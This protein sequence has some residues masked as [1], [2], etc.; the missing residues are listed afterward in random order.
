MSNEITKREQANPLALNPEIF[1]RALRVPPP[2]LP[3]DAGIWDGFVDGFR[4]RR[5]AKLS[6][7]DLEIARNTRQAF[8][9]N[10]AVVTKIM[11]MQ[12]DMMT[13]LAENH[14]NRNMWDLQE[15]QA[16]AIIERTKAETKIMEENSKFN[17]ARTKMELDYAQ[18]VVDQNKIKAKKMIIEFK[19]DE[20]DYRKRHKELEKEYGADED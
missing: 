16:K 20:L 10:M 17:E 14:H 7:L 1:Q 5:D 15:E 13:H 2:Q 12:D 4:K 3:Y 9:E 8:E 11:T 18:T 6:A 19:L